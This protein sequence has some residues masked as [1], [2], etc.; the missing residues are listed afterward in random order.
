[1]EVGQRKSVVHEVVASSHDAVFG[2]NR[3]GCFSFFS[4]VSE[5]EDQ[6]EVG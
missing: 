1:M 2:A 6:I 4:F 3:S 5:P